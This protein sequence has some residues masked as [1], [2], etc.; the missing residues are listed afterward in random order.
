MP[1]ADVNAVIQKLL[2]LGEER[3]LRVELDFDDH[4]MEVGDQ[5]VILN[6]KT[7]IESNEQ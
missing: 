6:G 3:G 1:D 5:S 7:V 4:E 2:A